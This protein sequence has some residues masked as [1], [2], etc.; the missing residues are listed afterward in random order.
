MNAEQV[1]GTFFNVLRPRFV[2]G[3]P[4]TEAE[5]QSGG[6]G[7]VISERLWREM[8]NADPHLATPLRTS[9]GAH[10]IIGVLADGQEF[11]AETDVWFPVPVTRASNPARTNVNWIHIARLRPGATAAQ[12]SAPS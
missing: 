12:A 11:P 3:R 4:F 7:V 10:T 8:F 6:A 2:I 5:A 9:N 1:S